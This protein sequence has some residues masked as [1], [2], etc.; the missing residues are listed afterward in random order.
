[1]KSAHH[2]VCPMNGFPDSMKYPKLGNFFESKC[3]L[4]IFKRKKLMTIVYPIPPAFQ[5]VCATEN[6]KSRCRV[7][8][9]GSS[10]KAKNEDQ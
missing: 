3:G 2:V 6:I 4:E 7:S 9:K 1:M 8:R 10:A 5:K